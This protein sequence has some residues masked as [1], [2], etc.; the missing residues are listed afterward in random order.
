M[1]GLTAYRGRG[2]ARIQ[3]PPDIRRSETVLASRTVID[4][5]S[6]LQHSLQGHQPARLL[7]LIACRDTAAAVLTLETCRHGAF[8]S[9]TLLHLLT[10]T[11][12][13]A[14]GPLLDL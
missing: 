9:Q 4:R 1:G 7:S 8:L 11:P 2:A 3:S 5:T 14:S 13:A 10:N 12:P 6:Q